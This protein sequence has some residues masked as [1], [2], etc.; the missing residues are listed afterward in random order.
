M[1]AALSEDS[2]HGKLTRCTEDNDKEGTNR[3]VRNA[4][5]PDRQGLPHAEPFS[6]A[7]RCTGFAHATLLNVAEFKG[8][9]GSD[10]KQQ[11][12]GR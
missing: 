3:F 1:P 5:E 12:Q 6:M 2:S 9:I 7:R 11:H 4:L 8:K 10:G